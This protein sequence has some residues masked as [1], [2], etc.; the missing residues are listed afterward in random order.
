MEKMKNM[1]EKLSSSLGVIGVAIYYIFRLFS[2]LLPFIMIG[3]PFFV[4]M[5]LIFI[6][7][8]VPFAIPVFWIWGLLSAFKGPQDILAMCYYII[9]SVC[10]L[11]LII[12]LI[13]EFI[14]PFFE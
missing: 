12:N 14:K 10:F 4:T 7:Q 5:I 2:S 13:K 3:A 6:A 11:P 9:F 1:K 8:V